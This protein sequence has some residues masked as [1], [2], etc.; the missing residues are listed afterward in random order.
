MDCSI[1][2]PVVKALREVW[3]DEDQPIYWLAECLPAPSYGN[4]QDTKDVD[5]LARAGS[6]GWIVITHDR[7]IRTRPAECGLMI[8]HKVRCFCVLAKQNPTVLE[9]VQ[10]LAGV[11]DDIVAISLSEQHPYFYGI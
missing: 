3:S 5:W 10:L 8:D 11:L 1:P 4:P 7:H 2:K 6:E 9:Y